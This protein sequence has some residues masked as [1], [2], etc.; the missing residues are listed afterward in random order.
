MALHKRYTYCMIRLS[1]FFHYL[2]KRAF[3]YL[4]LWGGGWGEWDIT[5][6]RIISCCR[7]FWLKSC[8]RKAPVVLTHAVHFKVNRFKYRVISMFEIVSVQSVCVMRSHLRK[9]FLSLNYRSR[10]FGPLYRYIH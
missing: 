8:K 10:S 5:Q 4:K 2:S 6:D 1:N 7:G 9:E 3:K